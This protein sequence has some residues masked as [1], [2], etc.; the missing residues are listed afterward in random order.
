M[1]FS[2]DLNRS[3]NEVLFA[4]YIS[5]CVPLLFNDHSIASFTPIF[6]I[7]KLFTSLTSLIHSI[8]RSTCKMF[9]SKAA[10]FALLPFFLEVNSQVSGTGKTTRYWDCC[11][12]SCAWS[13]KIT[14][15][16]GAHPV[17]TCDKNDNFISDVDAKS[18]CDG[19]G[20]YSM[21]HPV[22]GNTPYRALHGI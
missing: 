15:A 14:L 4:L 9:V 18:G 10:L 19:G 13:K 22:L 1:T 21:L 5:H 11:K 6:L 7:A 20:A 8:P 16:S 12:P 2:T 3:N 17:N